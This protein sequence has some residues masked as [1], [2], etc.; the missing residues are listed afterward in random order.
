MGQKPKSHKREKPR[1]TEVTCLVRKIYYVR[2]LF[3]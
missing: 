1:I 2:D 3:I